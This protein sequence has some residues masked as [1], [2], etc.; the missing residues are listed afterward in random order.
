MGEWKT[1]VSEIGTMENS[2]IRKWS[3][4]EIFIP[5]IGSWSNILATMSSSGESFF[6]E[7]VVIEKQLSDTEAMEK[8]IFKSEKEVMKTHFS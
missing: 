4:G 8:Y 1:F 3:N 6:Q 2:L 5:K 7:N